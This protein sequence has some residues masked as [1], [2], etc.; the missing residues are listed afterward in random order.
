MLKTKL[1]EWDLKDF[2]PSHDSEMFK[3]ELVNLK[4]LINKFSESNKGKLLRYSEKKIEIMIEDFEKIEEIIVKIKS[5]IFLFHCTDQLNQ[6]K[7]PFIKKFKK[8]SLLLRV[9]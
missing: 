2:Y 6:K 5:Y 9:S 8:K 1:P 4:A 7:L 3:N